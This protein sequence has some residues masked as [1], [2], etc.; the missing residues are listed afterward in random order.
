MQKYL[1]YERPF[2]RLGFQ[3][4]LCPMP[5]FGHSPML[6]QGFRLLLAARSIISPSAWLPPKPVILR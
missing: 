1:K 6:F 4:F 3:H 2:H 5:V